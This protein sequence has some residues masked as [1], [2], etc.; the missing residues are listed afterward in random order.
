MNLPIA[1]I[2]DPVASPAAGSDLSPGQVADLVR[3]EIAAGGGA[4]DG[5]VHRDDGEAHG[6]SI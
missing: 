6:R 4:R 2:H 5:I 1:P 3:G